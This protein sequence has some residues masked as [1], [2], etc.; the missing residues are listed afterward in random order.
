[1]Y[2]GEE[3]FGVLDVRRDSLAKR[4]EVVVKEGVDSF[5]VVPIP[6]TMG[7]LGYMDFGN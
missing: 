3:V 2:S 7:L 1:M 5:G 4:F 6:E